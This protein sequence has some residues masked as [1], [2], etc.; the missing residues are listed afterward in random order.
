MS[1]PLKTYNV[2]GAATTVYAAVDEDLLAQSGA[3][4]SDCKIKKPHKAALDMELAARLWEV[5][6]QQ[7]AAC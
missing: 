1:I 7:L 6:E 3:Y 2:Q 4:L 5:T